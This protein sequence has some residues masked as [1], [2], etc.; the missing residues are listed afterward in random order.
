[1][2]SGLATSASGWPSITRCQGLQ[3]PRR[4]SRCVMSRGGRA[5]S[6]L[7]QAGSCSPITHPCRSRSSSERLKRCSPDG[8]IW[9]SAVRHAR[10]KPAEIGAK[11]TSS[12]RDRRRNPFNKFLRSNRA[13]ADQAN[14]R[15]HL[16]LEYALNVEGAPPVRSQPVLPQDSAAAPLHARAAH[17]CHHFPSRRW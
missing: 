3:V 5:P 14:L 2:P 11:R 12:G 6:V 17:I 1:M 16:I 8:L 10:T 4:L 13:H 7:G 15:G 9:D